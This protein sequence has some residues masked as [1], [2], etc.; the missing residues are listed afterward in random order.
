[1]V[2]KNW[3]SRGI[4]EWL[5]KLWYMNVTKYYC[6]IKKDEQTDFTKTWKDLYELMLSEVRGTRRT[7]YTATGC[8]HCLMDLAL[9]SNARA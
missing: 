3:K 8:N 2:A 5:N 6:A 7:L 4:G 9:L 1:M